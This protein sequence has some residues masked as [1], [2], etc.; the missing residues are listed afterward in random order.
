M[1]NLK[2]IVKQIIFSGYDSKT[3]IKL[4]RANQNHK[5]IILL[6]RSKNRISARF[7][8][9]NKTNLIIVT[10]FR[11]KHIQ[12]HVDK[13]FRLVKYYMTKQKHFITKL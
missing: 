5:R 7:K 12:I 6:R 11:G 1:K 13:Y 10:V 4:L 3:Y 2:K 9:Y 8:K